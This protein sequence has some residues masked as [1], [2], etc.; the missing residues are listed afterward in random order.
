MKVKELFES[1][2]SNLHEFTVY[3]HDITTNT[4]YENSL[5]SIQADN[6]LH[7]EWKNA[8]ILAWSVTGTEFVLTVE[9][10]KRS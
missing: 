10:E 8:V 3:I 5:E 1:F 7:S 2:T 9:K 4:V 6:D